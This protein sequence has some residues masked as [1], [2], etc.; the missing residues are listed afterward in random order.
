MDIQ[1]SQIEQKT[2]T[3][4]NSFPPQNTFIDNLFRQAIKNRSRIIFVYKLFY[5]ILL[6]LV[7]FG[8]I[9]AYRVDENYLTMYVW[10][11]RAGQT[12][13]VFYIL[14]VIPGICRRFGIKHKLISLLMIFRRYNG[15]AIFLCIL[16][17]F[18]VLRG[19]GYIRRG[20]IN[21]HMPLFELLG[22]TAFVLTTFLFLTSN[23][24]SVQLFKAGWNKIH[25][26][27]YVIIWFIALHLLL[28]PISIWSI[29]ISVTVVLQLTSYFYSRM[30]KSKQKL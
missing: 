30:K 1:D 24:F 2:T 11:V 19:A 20:S 15:I 27:T 28:Q 29:S 5:A 7:V 16:T 22:L 18:M 10:A 8:G 23:D 9:S 12:G 25:K 3:A 21:F 17:H 14:T 26:L 4:Q 13:L 6:A